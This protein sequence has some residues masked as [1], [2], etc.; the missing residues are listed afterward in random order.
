MSSTNEVNKEEEGI[1]IELAGADEELREKLVQYTLEGN[2]IEV[3]KIYRSIPKS[4][5]ITVNNSEDT[6]LHV[7]VD[8]D[9]EN[10]V[11]DLVSIIVE[12][13]K[14]AL[15]KGNKHGDTPLHVA[16]SRG[17]ARL[18]KCIIGENEERIELRTLKNKNGETPLFLA[19]LNGNKKAFAYLSQTFHDRHQIILPHLVRHHQDSILH[20]VI[21]REYFDLAVIIAHNFPMLTTLRNN[22]D[23]T[24][25]KVL[26]TRPSAFPSGIK[27]S[28]WKRILYHCTDD[29]ETPFLLAARNGIVEMVVKIRR[30]IPSVIH[31][32][33]SKKENV[34]LVA[35]KHRQPHVVEALKTE[36]KDEVWNTLIQAVDDDDNTVLH[37][38][39]HKQVGSKPWN[40]AGTALEMMWDIKWYQKQQG[41]KDSRGDLSDI[42]RESCGKRHV[43]LKETSQACSVVAALV[44]GVSFATASQFP[45][46]TNGEG[47]PQLEG[48]A[49]FHAFAMASLVGLCFSVTGLIM[50]LCILTSRKEAKDFRRALPLKLLLGLSSLFVSIVAM[51][52]SFCSGNF[53]IFSGKYESFLLSFYAAT[54]VPFALYALAQ[55]PLYFDLLITI[56]TRVPWPSN[57]ADNF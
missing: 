3:K 25:L 31:N 13:E 56:V 42:T 46:G 7:A 51:V 40:V 29:E 47:K 41:V 1:G 24:P 55:F 6:A 23:G 52:V 39:A 28:W 43:W 17:F 11:K 14:S 18:C 32:T 54:S 26:A 22:K 21:Q 20:C 16:A 4:R 50:F 33:N 36:L 49:A 8:L 30:L 19:A 44:A 37:L 10:V 15:K 45:G 27:F 53:F 34:V 38:A 5:T 2:W 48:E 35:V 9:E 57:K 12:H